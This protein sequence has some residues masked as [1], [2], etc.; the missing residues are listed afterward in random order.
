MLQISCFGSMGAS[1]LVVVFAGI[2]VYISMFFRRVAAQGIHY[3]HPNT[4]ASCCVGDYWV[5][6]LYL[7]ILF[8][9]NASFCCARGSI[10]SCCKAV[11]DLH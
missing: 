5:V 2:C 11:N 4:F 10:G 1:A 9:G 3:H 8:L 7:Q 6:T